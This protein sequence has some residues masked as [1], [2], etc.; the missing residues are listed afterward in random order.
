MAFFY[1]PHNP[2]LTKPHDAS[3]IYRHAKHDAADNI[4]SLVT[5]LLLVAVAYG[6]YMLYA[7]SL[8][9]QP[10]AT[11]LLST[12]VPATQP[13][14]QLRHLRLRSAVFAASLL[15]ADQLPTA[16]FFMD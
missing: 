4:V 6:L 1:E 10:A 8:P 14:T 13:P 7:G 3:G 16:S 9:S 11:P 15:A 12:E 2:S 5:L